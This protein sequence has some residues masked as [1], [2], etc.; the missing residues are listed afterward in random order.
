MRME[1]SKIPRYRNLTKPERILIAQW[2]K[3]GR[4]NK[5]IARELGRSV[6]TIGR[7]IKRN[8]FEGK[9]YEPLHA[10]AKAVR[11][12]VKAWEVKHPLKSPKLFS[13]IIDKLR[14]GWSPEQISG[15]LK[16]EYPKDSSWHIC[17]ETIYAFIYSL[18]QK[19]KTYW[20]YLRRKQKTRRK[21]NGRKVQRVRIP[22][23][24]SIHI[25]PD[26]VG[27]RKVPGHWEG[28][29]IV[30]KGHVSGIHTE[31]ER[32]TSI[33]RLEKLDRINADETLKAMRRIFVPLPMRMKRTVTLDN[34]SEMV[35]HKEVGVDT[36]FADP[37]SAYQRGGNENA[38]LWIRYYFPKGTD[39]VKVPE[40]DIK[41][42]EWELNNRPRKRLGFKTPM[43][44]WDAALNT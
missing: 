1:V 11:R 29:S 18:R 44:V 5:W 2:V 16:L 13:Y 43:E 15:R 9:A 33:I 30:G 17:H 26:E 14:D 32:V 38:N 7:E 10:H 8:S 31:Y 12:R 21:R 20:E 27:E 25:R 40:E 42:V 24:V 22:D 4:S 34:G 39:F 28:D 19:D 36:F 37:Y 35:K 23:R 41:A 6:S 3:N